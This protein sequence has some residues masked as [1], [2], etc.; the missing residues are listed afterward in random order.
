MKWYKNLEALEKRLTKNNGGLVECWDDDGI[1]VG[2]RAF[3]MV[4]YYGQAFGI[5]NSY[6]EFQ[7][8]KTEEKI[9]IEYYLDKGWNEEYKRESN[10]IFRFIG[11]ENY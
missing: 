5:K 7:N 1:S 9:V 10:C 2:R 8:K 4:S 6:A 3:R 11:I